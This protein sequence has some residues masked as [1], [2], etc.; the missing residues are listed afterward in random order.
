MFDSKHYYDKDS[1]DTETLKENKLV[2]EEKNLNILELINLI[3]NRNEEYIPNFI[4]DPLIKR[5]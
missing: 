1:Y 4:S 5:V 2:D 3:E